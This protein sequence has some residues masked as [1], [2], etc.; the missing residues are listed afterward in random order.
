MHT[1]ELSNRLMFNKQVPA[2]GLKDHSTIG[3]EHNSDN[4]GQGTTEPEKTTASLLG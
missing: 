3:E 4:G 2:I 1:G